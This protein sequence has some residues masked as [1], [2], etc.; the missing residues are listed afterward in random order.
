MLADFLAWI[1]GHFLSL[2]L[3][4]L[5]GACFLFA[6]LIGIIVFR[7]KDLTLGEHLTVRFETPEPVCPP[8]AVK[9]HRADEETVV[10]PG[11]PGA[12]PPRH[13]PTIATLTGADPDQWVAQQD[14]IAAIDTAADA[15]DAVTQA[16]EG[17]RV[18]PSA[19][20]WPAAGP[21]CVTCGGPFGACACYGQKSAPEETQVVDL[22]PLTTQDIEIPTFGETPEHRAIA[23][24]EP[25]QELSRKVAKILEATK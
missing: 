3:L 4:M 13:A 18:I 11:I 16:I 23:D 24:R 14:W 6:G 9:S 25:T 5:A 21:T 7:R 17:L 19:E 8:R 12:L 1:N 10:V 20:L 22:C 15:T 2:L